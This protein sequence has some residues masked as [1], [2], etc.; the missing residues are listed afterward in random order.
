MERRGVRLA[1]ARAARGTGDRADPGAAQA[2]AHG[3]RAGAGHRPGGAGPARRRPHGDLLDALGAEL[4][5]LGGVPVPRSAFD[6]SRLPAHL[7]ITFRVVD[8]GQ[9]L[10]AGKDLA[11]LRQQLRPRLQATLAEAARGLTRTGLR[12]WDLATLPRV[13][14]HGQ[15]R[16]YP[17]LADAGDAVDIRLFETEAEAEAAM[18]AGHPAAAAARGA[19]RGAR[20]GQPAADQRQAGDEP[21]PVPERRRAAGRLRGCRGR[22]GDHRSGRPGVGR[23]GFRPAAGGGPDRAGPGHRRRGRAGGP[24]PGRG[25]R[26]RSQPRPGPQPRRWPRVTPTCAASWPG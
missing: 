14:S 3:V 16:A 8:G 13:F 6:L 11:V 19:V 25:A 12:S 20:G 23:G 7:R 4:G 1:G 10:A 22:S 26:G 17:A 21:A 18:R 9:V 15:V 24:G 5:R 2:A